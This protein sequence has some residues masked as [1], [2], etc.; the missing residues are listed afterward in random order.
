MPL[1]VLG[2][3]SNIHRQHHLTRALDALATLAAPAPLRLSPVYESPAVGFEDD[4]PFYNL[5]VAFETELSP[6]ALND[7]C[8]SIERDNGRPAGPTKFVARTLDIDLL[9]W[10]DA[11]GRHG[12]ARLPREDILRYAFV[13][14]P[15]L[16]AAFD[17]ADQSRD[18]PHWP[19]DFQWRERFVSR[20]VPDLDQ[21][22]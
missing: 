10:G 17:A 6:T 7:R 2:L 20:A 4:R 18:Q 15:L 13:L 1:A 5:V 19:V 22:R 16:W 21:E 9:L 14:H 3:G 12:D 8:K 11:V